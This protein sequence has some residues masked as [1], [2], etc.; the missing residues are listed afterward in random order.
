MIKTI[1]KKK[2]NERKRK[3]KLKKM[4]KEMKT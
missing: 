1:K 2:G 3:Q 4:G